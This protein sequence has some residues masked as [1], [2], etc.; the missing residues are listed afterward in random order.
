MIELISYWKVA[1]PAVV[2]IKPCYLNKEQVNWWKKLYFN[3]LGE[4]FYLNRIRTDIEDFMKVVIDSE[5][6]LAAGSFKFND[7]ILV[8]VGGGKDSSVTLDLL[9]RTFGDKVLPF[10]LNSRGAIQSVISRAG[11]D[12]DKVVEFKRIIDPV[13]IDLNKKGYLNGH[14][15][16]SALLAYL[17]LL[18]AVLTGS[19]DIVLSNESSADEATDVE[20][21]ANHQ[22]SKTY[23]FERDFR[24]YVSKYINDE[25]N[26]FSFLRPLTESGISRLFSRMPQYFEVFKSCNAG[27]KTDSWCCKCPKCLFTTII[28]APFID[29]KTIVKIFGQNI[30]HDKGL[31]PILQQLTGET[32]SK[33]FEC[34]GTIDEVR[35]SLAAV[36]KKYSEKE[37]PVLLRYFKENMGSDSLLLRA[38]DIYHIDFSERHFLNDRYLKILLNAIS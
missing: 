37:L 38:D 32:P 9:K 15:P 35:L 31:I 8:P 21:G 13:L 30:L 24:T 36:I 14:T 2:R 18:A 20:S 10:V 25:I 3:G 34:V 22:Y 27:S 12:S 5:D 28:L 23:E 19:K 26:Y 17:T 4:F 16:F 29:E 6:H 33:P 7:T 1:C 11:I